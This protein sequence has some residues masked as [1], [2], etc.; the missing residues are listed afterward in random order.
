MV[1]YD[2]HGLYSY[3]MP[4]DFFLGVFSSYL[5]SLPYQMAVGFLWQLQHHLYEHT[6]LQHLGPVCPNPLSD[7][8]KQLE[9]KLL[10]I[11]IP[12][13]VSIDVDISSD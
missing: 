12:R 11:V 9:M 2:V 4:M 10:S 13:C 8:K 7:N 5:R 6:P 3:V 1:S